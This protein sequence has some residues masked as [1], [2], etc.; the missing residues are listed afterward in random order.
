MSDISAIDK[1]FDIGS[2]INKKGVQFYDVKSAP[3][4]IHGLMYSGGI[5]H[6]IPIGVAENV[7]DGVRHLNYN[8][9]GGRVRFRTDSTYVAISAKYSSLGK[10]P[11]FAFCGSIG[12]DLYE[13]T[14]Y[15]K[16]F[17]PAADPQTEFESVIDLGEAKMRDITINFPLYS[18]VNELYIGL[19]ENAEIEQAEPYS[20]QKP[21]VF[22]GSS[23]T[24]G[25]C[26]SRPGTCYE[27][28]VSRRFNVDYVNLGF[29][30]SARAEDAVID[31]IKALEM[32][33]FVYDYDHN[34]PTPEYLEAT[35]EKMFLA[36][37]ERNPSLP[38]IIMSRPLHRLNRTADDERRMGIV[39]RTYENA[40]ARKDDNVYLL[41]GDNLTRLCGNEGTVD[42]CHPTDLGFA[43][44]ADALIRLIEKED[45]LASITQ[46]Q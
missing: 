15:V 20:N 8:T 19:D 40:K 11:H 6:R 33:L 1:N 16:T 44:M 35:H 25:G 17:S 46:K 13:G 30:G 23:I 12:F 41:N 9:A 21:I 34:A 31:Y 26:A 14:R 2:T 37:R 24:Q 43:S 5:F 27:A 38:I 18:S 3:F 10:M 28:H 22:Y 45:L 4:S 42:N 39:T 32:S 36:V 7:N 29:S